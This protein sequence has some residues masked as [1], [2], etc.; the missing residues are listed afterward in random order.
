MK[1]RSMIASSYMFFA[2]LNA[3]YTDVSFNFS[4]LNSDAYKLAMRMQRADNKKETIQFVFIPM[5]T[6]TANDSDFYEYA[7]SMITKRSHEISVV[8][9]WPLN[10][11]VT[12]NIVNS[13]FPYSKTDKS[14][15]SLQDQAEE[16]INVNGTR[17]FVL[18]LKNNNR[19]YNDYNQIKESEEI[20]QKFLRSPSKRRPIHDFLDKYKI[21]FFIRE[22]LLKSKLINDV[23]TNVQAQYFDGCSSGRM[24]LCE[25]CEFI[26]N[27][28]KRG[29]IVS[30]LSP[31]YKTILSLHPSEYFAHISNKT[32]FNMDLTNILDLA[33]INTAYS[34]L[35]KDLYGKDG[36]Y[37]KTISSFFRSNHYFNDVTEISR[38]EVGNIN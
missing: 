32:D 20:V 27:G 34:P 19:K 29:Y 1:L 30:M 23:F 3:T 26:M 5:A 6:I 25:L 35:Y 2:A 9:I 13:L 37:Y 8:D 38:I 33:K 12:K 31:K 36:L 11:Q 4:K 17:L 10:G 15:Q 21:E 22:G 18:D 7:K 28:F 24:L 14:Y 16:M